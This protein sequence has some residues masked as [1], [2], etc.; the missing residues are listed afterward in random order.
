MSINY[1]DMTRQFLTGKIE[2][3]QSDSAETEPQVLSEGLSDMQS[4]ATPQFAAAIKGE[5]ISEARADGTISDGEDQQ[6]EEFL[7]DVAEQVDAL[8]DFIHASSY[9]IGGDFRGPGIR[10]QAKEIM[11]AKASRFRRRQ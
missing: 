2:E 6:R 10:A 11:L 9:R 7:A 5:D 3:D 8:I 1:R 4:L